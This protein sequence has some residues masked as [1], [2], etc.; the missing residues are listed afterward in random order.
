M[1]NISKRYIYILLLAGYSYLNIQFTEADQLLSDFEVKGIALFLVLLFIIIGIWEGNRLIQIRIEKDKKSFMRSYQPLILVFLLSILNVAIITIVPGYFIIKIINA[2]VNDVWFHLKLLFGF[3]F[4]VNLFLNSINAIIHFINVSKESQLEAEKFKK[5]SVEA[6]F[7]ALRNQINPHFLF[8]SLNVLST[9]VYKD[10]DLAND[11]IQQLSKVYR[12]LINNQSKKIISL[13]EELSF[14]NSYIYLL[15]IRFKSNL[16]IIN[17]INGNTERYYIAPATLQLLIENAIKHNIVS[18]KKPLNIDI[19][20]DDN[21]IIVKNNLQKKKQSK[22]NNT[23]VGLKN[24]QKR[25]QLM[26]NILL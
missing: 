17:N 8:N 21:F 6:Q 11:F 7:E 25:Y 9:L 19:F 20:S 22:Q 24:I 1:F 3:G 12:Y 4:R 15:N 5:I 14:I 18:Y 16:K 2:P 10:Q 23:R 26:T 13:T